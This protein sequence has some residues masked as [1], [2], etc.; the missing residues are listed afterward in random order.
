MKEKY[1]SRFFSGKNFGEISGAGYFEQIRLKNSH[2]TLLQNT[3]FLLLHKEEHN[4]R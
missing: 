4:Y 3:Y 2:F 1:E